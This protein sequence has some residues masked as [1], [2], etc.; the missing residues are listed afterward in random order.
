MDARFD[1]VGIVTPITD[2]NKLNII[3]PIAVNGVAA[4]VL[5]SI[6]VESDGAM[7]RQK[8]FNDSMK[9]IE[10]RPQILAESVETYAAPDA[11]DRG[12]PRYSRS[13]DKW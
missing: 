11:P 7:A 5:R 8:L 12:T 3:K 4:R 9:L 10:T 1:A 13:E 6:E 2:T